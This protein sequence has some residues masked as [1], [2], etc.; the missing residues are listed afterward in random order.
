VTVPEWLPAQQH[1]QPPAD[2]LFDWLCGEGSLTRRL[3]EAG[4]GD[5]RVELLHQSVQ[6]ARHDEALA[7]NIQP[8]DDV[9]C[10]E[11]LLHTAGAPRVFARSVAPLAS[12]ADSGLDLET[13]GTR[14]LGEVL[15]ADARIERSAIEISRYPAAWLPSSCSHSGLWG[16]RSQ[17][18]H[19]SLRLLVCEVFLDGWP[20]AD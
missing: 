4:T 7:L 1:P 10:R 17:F 11:V 5:F 20:P 18:S 3:I 2:P 14:S 12:L 13:L 19:A 15:F 16:R 8:G 9:W 6:P